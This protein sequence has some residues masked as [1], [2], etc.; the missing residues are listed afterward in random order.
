M[1]PE[2]PPPTGEIRLSGKSAD[3]DE[4]A[5]QVLYASPDDELKA[6]YTAKTGES[7]TIEVLDAI[8]ANVAGVC[9]DMGDFVAEVKR[10]V[11]NEWRNPAGFLR[12]LSKRL[13]RKN[14]AASAPVTAAEA[15][16]LNY[17]CAIC[18]SRTKG[19]GALLT[20]GKLG[21]CSCASP[22][23]IARQRTR[24]IFPEEPPQ[25]P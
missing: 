20:N 14:Q 18:N 8:R 22:E 11:K 3:D 24:G 2:A 12:D 17:R 23:Y 16:A 21:P 10:H 15:A 7:I 9:S 25:C 19:E 5:P 1:F 13:R 4:K 6:I